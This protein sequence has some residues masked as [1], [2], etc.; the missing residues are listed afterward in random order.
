MSKDR[1]LLIKRREFVSQ[2]IK[3]NQK[4]SMKV[5]VSELSERLFIS[6]R[7]VWQDIQSKPF[8]KK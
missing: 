5:L 3:D 1:N 8:L 2:Y 4:K 6:E 7:C